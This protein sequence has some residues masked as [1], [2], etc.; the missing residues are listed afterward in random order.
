LY[1]LSF[2]KIKSTEMQNA[3]K[4]NIRKRRKG[5]GKRSKASGFSWMFSV[6]NANTK[7]KVVEQLVEWKMRESISCWC[8]RCLACDTLCYEVSQCVTCSNGKCYRNIIQKKG[9]LSKKNF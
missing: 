3:D 9:K 2:K 5:F 8:Y 7:E 6:T 1:V 4:I